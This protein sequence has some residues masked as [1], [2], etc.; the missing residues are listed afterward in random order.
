M[1]DSRKQ[2]L[3]SRIKSE[4]LPQP[5]EH[6]PVE[7]VA[8]PNPIGAAGAYIKGSPFTHI[9]EGL[10]QF[11]VGSKNLGGPMA[12]TRKHFANR[13]KSISADE[14]KLLKG[15]R[16]Q[17]GVPRVHTI[18]RPDGSIGYQKEI[19]HYGGV[20]GVAQKHPL[21]TGLVGGGAYLLHKSKPPNQQKPVNPYMNHPQA[22]GW[23]K[24]PGPQ[25][26][27]PLSTG[28]WG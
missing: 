26:P 28:K 25:G 1:L 20:T 10:K 5:L 13:M 12:G 16:N 15:Q 7:K 11:F 14:Y 9:G 19:Y 21:M 17:P 8:V 18:K 22:R 27:A 23:G 4:I 24:A 6:A 3:L 2:S